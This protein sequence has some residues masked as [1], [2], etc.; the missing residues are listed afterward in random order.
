MMARPLK[1]TP[2]ASRR[3]GFSG[4]CLGL[5]FLVVT[6]TSHLRAAGWSAEP[7]PDYDRLFQRTNGWTGADGDFAVSLTNGLVLWLFSDTYIG[8][9][10]DGHRVHGAMVN[11]S[12]AWQ[13]GLDPASARVEFFHG[14]AADGKPA[15]LIIPADGHGWFWLFDAVMV[16]GILYLF[17]QQIEHTDT[18]SVFGFR[19]TGAWLGEVANPLDP[20]D[21]WRITQR[22]LPF[23]H[24][25]GGVN[26]DFG[27]AV[28]ATNGFVYI[29]GVREHPGT[30]KQ[31]I[32]ARAPDLGLADFTAWQ[33]RT[34]TGW[35]N[36]I[37]AV[38][39]LCPELAS[40][41]SVSRLPA[42]G[43][44]VLVCTENGMSEKIV[45]RTA[46]EPWGPWSA[47]TVVYRC[48]DTSWGGRIFCY[49]GKAHPMLATNPNELI[50]TYAANSYDM[51]QVM[52]DARLYWPRFV[53][54]GW[55]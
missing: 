55:Q 12:A 39:N 6:A 51:A 2:P 34:A 45:V 30:D 44:Y 3:L 42:L 14:R 33:F 26:Q 28:L 31:M 19:Q 40:E 22:R 21:R 46:P 7:W 18:A 15:S 25:G 11:N 32:L 38:A 9:V 37:A 36:D 5:L 23:A 49:A 17:L 52:Q 10:R 24:F 50:V 48:P 1:L 53:K 4:G 41:Y 35:T 47:P 20:P 54:I 29:Y 13:H 43:R 27:S 8:E 16:R